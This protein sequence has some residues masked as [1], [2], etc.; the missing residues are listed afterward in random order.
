MTNGPD[1]ATTEVAILQAHRQAACQGG[2][3]AR[4]GWR[5]LH[6]FTLRPINPLPA[7]SCRPPL[8]WPPPI[9]THPTGDPPTGAQHCIPV[10]MHPIG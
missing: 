9:G 6:A 8:H 3:L 2:K 5:A 7:S 10:I 4:I 1:P